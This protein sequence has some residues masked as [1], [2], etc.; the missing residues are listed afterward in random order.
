[1]SSTTLPAPRVVEARDPVVGARFERWA[2]ADYL[3][4]AR[5]A[6][7]GAEAEPSARRGSG[8]RSWA[9]VSRLT[10]RCATRRSP[11]E[12]RAEANSERKT[13]LEEAVDEGARD[14]AQRGSSTGRSPRSRWTSRCPARRAARPPAPDH[15]DP[16]GGRRRLPRARLPGRRRPRGRDDHYNFTALNTPP[17][18]PSRSPQRHALRRR[19]DVLRTRRRRRRSGSW[20]QHQPPVYMVYLGRVYRRDTPDATHTRSSTRSRGSP[21]TGD[22][23]RRPEG[24]AAPLM[25]RAL[26]R[27][28]GG[29]LPHAATSRSPSRRSSSTSP[30][31]SATGRAVASCKFSGWIE[32]GGPEWSTRTSSGTSATTLRRSGLRVRARAR[33]DRHAPPR[34][35]RP[36]RVLGERPPAPRPV[37]MKVPVSWLREYVDFDA[38]PS[39]SPSGSRSRP[40]RSSGSPIAASSTRTA[41][42]A[43]SSS[44]ACSRPASIRTR[45]GCSSAGRHRRGRAAADRLRRLELRRG[46]DRRGR[47]ARRGAPGRR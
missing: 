3:E 7:V 45:T 43:S 17:G 6:I 26:R 27:G 47:A 44:G 25:P 40:S 11:V 23:A 41:T 9:A 5:A 28:T 38:A 42:S 33:A 16:P 19:R 12:E 24:D 4:E 10:R 13:A 29:S 15:A 30:A 35:P 8:S 21:S 22:H 20:R 37:L 2:W 39:S 36:A 1:M 34:R 32:M 31:S 18:H 14:A 46:R